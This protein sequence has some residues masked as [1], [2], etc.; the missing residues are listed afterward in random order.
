VKDAA[1]FATL[2]FLLTSAAAGVPASV[3]EER[4]QFLGPTLEQ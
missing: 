3:D 4:N 2:L 1:A